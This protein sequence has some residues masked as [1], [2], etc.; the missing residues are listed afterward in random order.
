MT[1]R[2]LP[3]LRVLIVV[4]LLA[5]LLMQAVVLPVVSA[6]IVRV[7]PRTVVFARTLVPLGIVGFCCV[8]AVLVCVWRLLSMVRDDTVMT[9]RSRAW[10]TA[11]IVALGVGTGVTAVAVLLPLVIPRPFAP[12]AGLFLLLVLAAGLGAL[13]LMLT[14]RALLDRSTE[15]R[16]ELDQV[17]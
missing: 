4:G 7:E 10:V 16:A 8:Q 17:I 9:A 12:A 11:L 15:L 6:E 2:F 13:L 3:L 5:C 14:M 1:V